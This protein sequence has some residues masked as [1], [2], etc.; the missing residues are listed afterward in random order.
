MEKIIIVSDLN[1][2]YIWVEDSLRKICLGGCAVNA[3]RSFSKY[4]MQP[5]IIGSVGNDSDGTKVKEL[6]EREHIEAILSENQYATGKCNIYF[7]DGKRTTSSQT[8]NSKK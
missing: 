4:G 7:K 2:D 6:L 3:A 1:L 8:V 5:V